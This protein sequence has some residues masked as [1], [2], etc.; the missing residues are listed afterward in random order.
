MRHQKLNVMDADFTTSTETLT[1]FTGRGMLFARRYRG[2]GFT[3]IELLVVIAI[4]AILIA[5]LLPAVQNAREAARRTQ[6]KNN[7]KQIALALHNYHDI[8]MRLPPGSVSG[9]DTSGNGRA[10]D[11]DGMWGW[12]VMILP[13]LEQTTLWNQLDVS[14]SEGADR[15]PNYDSIDNSSNPLGGRVFAA[16]V[17]PSCPGGRMNPFFKMNAKANYVG[18]HNLM[19]TNSNTVFRDISDGTSNTL[20]VAERV[21]LAGG[22]RKSIGA[23]WIG[24]EQCGTGAARRFEAASE[25]NTPFSGSLDSSTNCQTGDTNQS[26][27]VASS[28]HAGGGQFALADGSVRFISETI[29]SNPLP[30]S[31]SNAADPGPGYIYQNLFTMDDGHVVGEF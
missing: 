1:P 21:L 12:Q 25:I 20:L 15:F 10:N 13:Q 29:A 9:R 30:G 11:F 4:I 26:R 8:Y 18:S 2:N 7:L 6:C 22:N 24:G 27:A 23:I 17:C 16:F 5:L 14:K 19:Y 3:L 28:A 31:D